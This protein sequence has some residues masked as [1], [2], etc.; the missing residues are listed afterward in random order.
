[1]KS[2]IICC[3]AFLWLM[4]ASAQKLSPETRKE[5]LKKEDS[6]K[7]EAPK[8]LVSPDPAER[9]R[10]DSILT[11]TLVRALRMPYSFYYPFDSLFTISK[12]YA[13]DSS[14]RIFTWQVPVN[15][16]L[17][18]QHGAI[19]IN[20][21][22]G[23][24]KLFPLIDK[25]E[26]VDSMEDSI[27]NHQNWMGAVY[28]KLLMKQVGGRKIYTLIGYDE[29]NSRS[30]K[31]I[32]EVL[33]FVQGEP[34][35]GA[36]IFRFPNNELKASNPARYIMEFKK[37]AG[38]RLTYDDELGMIIMEHLVSESNEPAKKHTLVGDGDYEGFRWNNGRWVYVSKIFNEVTPEGKAPVPQPIRDDKGNID[39]SKL[40]P[41]EEKP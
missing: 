31:K 10:V 20:S 27:G 39:E 4:P 11:R 9:L 14:F 17:V 6:L 16:D 36:R 23:S 34:R 1:M 32:I 26:V 25:S 2:C 21:P 37:D 15:E 40:K 7:L 3:L 12:L 22:D 19:Q 38:P 28:Y 30:N 29:N 18:R 5:L 35:F 13:P 41:T 33:E 24:L 8:M